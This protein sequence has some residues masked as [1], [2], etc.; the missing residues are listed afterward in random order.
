ML[1]RRVTIQKKP[2]YSATIRRYNERAVPHSSHDF[3][4]YGE[5]N[6]VV[7]DSTQSLEEE[8]RKTVA[9]TLSKLK[10]MTLSV[11]DGDFPREL[12]AREN[13]TFAGNKMPG[14]RNKP[15]S[16]DA[17]LNAPAPN[18]QGVLKIG[19]VLPPNQRQKG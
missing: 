3:R 16:Y 4:N 2:G 9:Q 13:L 11:I 8:R 7:V 5:G 1:T 14:K 6:L 18:K 19:A 15:E 10:G 12:L 17:K